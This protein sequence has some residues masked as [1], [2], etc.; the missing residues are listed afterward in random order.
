MW[1]GGEGPGKGMEGHG[2]WA[3]DTGGDLDNILTFSGDIEQLTQ[4][5][6]DLSKPS[7]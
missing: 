3:A 2:Q 5:G 1:A 4:Q 6:G 7:R